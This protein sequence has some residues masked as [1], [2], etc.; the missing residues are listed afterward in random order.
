MRIIGK[1]EKG[2]KLNYRERIMFKM[3]RKT[4]EEWRRD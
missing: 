1:E 4:T 3:V 2:E